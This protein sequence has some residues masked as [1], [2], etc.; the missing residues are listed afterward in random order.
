MIDSLIKKRVR[1]SL[2]RMLE[3]NELLSVV[4]IDIEE[5][6]PENADELTTANF[7]VLCNSIED[8]CGELEKNAAQL[9]NVFETKLSIKGEE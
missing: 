9:A 3:L 8:F 4:A 5:S 6:I 1:F 2:N 7:Q